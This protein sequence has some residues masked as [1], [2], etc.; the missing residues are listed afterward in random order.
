MK[1]VKSALLLV[2]TLLMLPSTAP[3]DVDFVLEINP[4]SYVI[5]P[6]IDN[7]YASNGVLLEE[8]DGVAVRDDHLGG[9]CRVLSRTACPV[10]RHGCLYR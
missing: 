5:S 4:L 10:V 9:F 8:I 2:L 1:K 6:D 3:A 7:F